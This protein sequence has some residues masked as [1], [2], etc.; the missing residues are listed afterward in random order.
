MSGIRLGRDF[1]C[2]MQ[3]EAHSKNTRCNGDFVERSEV[4]GRFC[5]ESLGLSNEGRMSGIDDPKSLVPASWP[6]YKRIP[7]KHQEVMLEDISIR[8]LAAETVVD[9]LTGEPVGELYIERLMNPGRTSAEEFTR[10]RTRFL[11]TGEVSAVDWTMFAGITG[12]LLFMEVMKGYEAEEFVFTKMAGTYPTQ[13]ISGER[14]PG[15]SPAVALDAVGYD[16]SS[17]AAQGQEDLLLKRPGKEFARG[18]MGENY[19]DLPDTELRGLIMEVDR[20]AIY[21]DR[22]GLIVQHAQDVG[23]KLGKHKELRGLRLLTGLDTVTPYKEKYMWDTGGALQLDAY[24]AGS[25]ALNSGS[26]QLAQS[27]ST[28][29]Y[30]FI[31]DVPANPLDNWETF[32]LSDLYFSRIVDPN[33]GWPLTLAGQDVFAPWSKRLDIPRILQAYQIYMITGGQSAGNYALGK[34]S[35]MT[36]S[37]N[38]INT[39]GQIRPQVSRLLTQVMLMASATYAQSGTGGKV[40]PENVWWTGDFKKAIRYMEN[41][42]IK[43][44]QRPPL[45]EAEFL[46]DVVLGYRA[47]ERGRWAWFDPRRLQRN[48]YLTP[49]APT[50]VV[51]TE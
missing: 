45:S 11:E 51:T 50:S 32:K 24:Q 40:D 49:T 15:V 44:I 28:R 47:D 2:R 42:P 29:K 17:T 8:D 35:I 18:T 46:Q 27:Y 5:E 30:P 19:L 12:P 23:S 3:E 43:V 22:T 48:N 39:L 21:T 34:G 41:W 10:H 25:T 33:D 6:N 16:Q 36:A 1:R 4:F 13:F 9:R 20:T 7:D 14:M 26:Y 37:P 38:P 31:N